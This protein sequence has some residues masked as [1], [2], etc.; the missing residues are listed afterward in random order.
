M[1]PTPAPDMA[2]R[3]TREDTRKW[4]ALA[5]GRASRNAPSSISFDA[6]RW[7]TSNHIR[8]AR[9]SVAHFENSNARCNHNEF[10]DERLSELTKLIT[11]PTNK[12][13]SARRCEQTNKRG[14]VSH[15]QPP[16]DEV[17]NGQVGKGN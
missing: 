7:A 6:L 8:C 12:R 14:Q 13:V 1:A 16:F 11:R 3:A 5:L 4:L 15:A 2:E 9:G 17:V 10:S